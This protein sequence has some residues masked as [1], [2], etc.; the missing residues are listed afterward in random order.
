MKRNIGETDRLIRLSVAC[1]IGVLYLT[2]LL[3]GLPGAILGLTALA[4]ATTGIG[5]FSPL[6]ALLGRNTASE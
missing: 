5:G 6:Y 1:V 3:S 4:A 2:G